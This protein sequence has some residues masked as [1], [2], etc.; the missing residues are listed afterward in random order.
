MQ[1]KI[2]ENVAGSRN[3]SHVALIAHGNSHC[4]GTRGKQSQVQ[5]ALQVQRPHC[6]DEKDS[7]VCSQQKSIQQIYRLVIHVVGRVN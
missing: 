6:Q 3:H 5:G 7:P 2:P 1:K 4:V